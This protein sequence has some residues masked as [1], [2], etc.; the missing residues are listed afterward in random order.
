MDVALQAGDASVT[1]LAAGVADKLRDAVAKYGELIIPTSTDG[2]VVLGQEFRMLA[3]HS[4][5]QP[6]EMGVLMGWLENAYGPEVA[7][8]FQLEVPTFNVANVPL[9]LVPPSIAAPQLL[10]PGIPA[11]PA[12]AATFHQMSQ[13]LY[14]APPLQQQLVAP[15]ASLTTATFASRSPHQAAD[16]AAHGMEAGEIALLTWLLHT[17][18]Q[19]P[20]GHDSI[21]YGV[22]PPTV[23]KLYREYRG[24]GTILW[25]MIKDEKTTLRDMQGHFHRAI[26]SAEGSPKIVQ[27]LADHWMEMQQHFDSVELMRSYYSRFLIMRAGRGLPKLVDEHIVMLVMVDELGRVR[28][29][30]SGAGAAET[31]AILDKAMSSIESFKATVTDLKT[32]VSDLKQEVNNLKNERWATSRRRSPPRRR[33]SLRIA[34]ATIA[35]RA[36]TR[37][38]SATSGSATRPSRLPRRW[39]TNEG[40]L[41]AKSEN[42]AWIAVR[43]VRHEL[44]PAL[45][46]ATAL[47]GGDGV[48]PHRM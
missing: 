46:H 13:G 11:T 25:D 20:P 32:K 3:N 22:D 37:R 8:R 6:V 34:S 24:S 4:A 26:Q 48:A 15:M 42:N 39:P 36:V 35:A 17:A 14:G 29:G 38:R 9:Q 10:G 18:R 2:R 19:P 43:G 7:A 40:A 1:P 28:R 44:P 47:G 23:T 41:G 31:T 33:R 16:E 5:L 45:L 12:G 27:R 30:A 21:K